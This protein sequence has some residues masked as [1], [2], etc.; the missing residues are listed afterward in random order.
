MNPALLLSS[1]KAVN[2]AAHASTDI[3]IERQSGH[4]SANAARQIGGVVH[5]HV[6]IRQKIHNFVGLIL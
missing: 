1:W 3:T 4:P 2:R 6:Y 5:M